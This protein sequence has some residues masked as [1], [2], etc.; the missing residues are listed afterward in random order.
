MLPPDARPATVQIVVCGMTI[1]QGDST[2]D[3]TMAHHPP[4]N[5]PM[6]SITV[7]QPATCTR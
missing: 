5:A 6:P 4:A 1:V 3:R 7:A 2:I